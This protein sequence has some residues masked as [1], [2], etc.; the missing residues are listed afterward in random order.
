MYKQC[1]L[2]LVDVAPKRAFALGRTG[3]GFP[4]ARGCSFR[5]DDSIVRVLTNG[6]VRLRFRFRGNVGKK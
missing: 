3:F 6:C 4:P 2:G 5:I 1:G